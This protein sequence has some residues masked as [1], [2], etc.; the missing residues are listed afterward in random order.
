LSAERAA[1]LRVTPPL[2][3][4]RLERA[5]AV[6]SDLV[7]SIRG[8]LRADESGNDEARDELVEEARRVLR[9]ASE[10]I[11]GGGPT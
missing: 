9:V 4:E 11:E 8:A 5:E 10:L 7:R 2:S 1:E 6:L 3:G